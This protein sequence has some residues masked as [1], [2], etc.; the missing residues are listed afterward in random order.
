[1]SD[2][3]DGPT[4]YC[5]RHPNRQSF[6]LCQ[7]C[8]RTICGECQIPMPV[9]VICPECAREGRA[10]TRE[11]QRVH[12]GPARVRV[13]RAAGRYAASDRPVMTWS[14][15]AVCGFVFLL[16]VIGAGVVGQLTL[17]G[18]FIDGVRGP[19]TE[20]LWYAGV[21]SDR[22]GTWSG[23]GFAPWRLLTSVFAHASVIHIA[24]NM[25]MLW[26]LGPMIEGVIGKWRYLVLFLLCGV[27]GSDGV[28]LMTDGRVPTLGASGA[29]FGVVAAS[30]V[31]MRR[32]GLP[33][34]QLVVWVAINQVFSFIGGGIAWQ[35]H[36]GGLLIGIAVGFIFFETRAER[37]RRAQSWLL[38]AMGFVLVVIGVFPAII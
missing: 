33:I 31:I 6:V 25:Y 29:I 9:G 7:R 26:V 36:I 8:G 34:T 38:A 19:V 4:G 13:A 14:L 24:F 32:M 2:F 18:L 11:Q 30:I 10:A 15:M 37:R 12:A 28:L 17:S 16:Q 1:V 22:S 27:A 5:Y 20:T 3:V 21:Y 35:A 23:I